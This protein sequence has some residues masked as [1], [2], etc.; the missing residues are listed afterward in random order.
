VQ[1]D[2]FFAVGS[3]LH[4]QSAEFQADALDDL[5]SEICRD[6]AAAWDWDG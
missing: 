2:R 4:D 3:A 5:L 6:V 1:R